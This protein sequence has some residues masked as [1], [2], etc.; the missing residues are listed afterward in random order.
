MRRDVVVCL[1]PGELCFGGVEQREIDMDRQ[2]SHGQACQ[3]KNKLRL[4]LSMQD[5]AFRE[6]PTTH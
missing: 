3:E 2:V 6:H 5:T 1:R 4:R